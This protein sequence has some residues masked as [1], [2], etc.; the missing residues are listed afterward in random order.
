M[1][2]YSICV[3]SVTRTVPLQLEAY[4][5]IRAHKY[6]TVYFTVAK[7]ISKILEKPLGQK[8]P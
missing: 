7:C 5:F 2:I 3:A 8:R 4:I 1:V 6:A